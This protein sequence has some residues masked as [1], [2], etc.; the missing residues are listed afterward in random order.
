MQEMIKSGKT[1][2]KP[3]AT[4]KFHEGGDLRRRHSADLISGSFKMGHTSAGRSQTCCLHGD[5]DKLG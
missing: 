3:M 4:V 1:R 2:N 5:D